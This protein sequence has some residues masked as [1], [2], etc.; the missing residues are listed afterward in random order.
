[1]I[2]DYKGQI[3]RKADHGNE[4][5]VPG[6]INI[7]SLREYRAQTGVGLML[8]QMRCDQWKQIYVRWPAYPKNAY[9]KNVPDR[10]QGRLSLHQGLARKLFEAGIFIPPNPKRG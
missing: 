4:A 5:Y 6:E 9:L 7:K 3:V 10:A 8:A 2:V 1:M